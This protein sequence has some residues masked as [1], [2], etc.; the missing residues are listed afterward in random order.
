M[1]TILII[2]DEPLILSNM[3]ELLEFEGFTV[4]KSLDGEDALQMIFAQPIDLILC[5]MLMQ[6]L[7]GFQILKAV[8]N[9]PATA[10]LPFVFV[11]AVKW[12]EEVETGATGYIYKPFQ[13][14]ELLDV[15]RQQLGQ[16]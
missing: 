15:V 2:D 10:R 3:A 6:T 14:D 5:D 9:N 8:R 16:F 1:A 12:D 13:N 7:N 4:L 11:T